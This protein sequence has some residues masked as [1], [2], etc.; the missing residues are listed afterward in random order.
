MHTVERQKALDDVKASL[1]QVREGETL[2]DAAE[3]P[4]DEAIA[5]EEEAAEALETVAEDAE[6]EEDGG[7]TYINEL[8]EQL[9]WEPSELFALKKRID[10]G[11][12]KEPFEVTLGE[13]FDNVDAIAANRAELERERAVLAEQAQALQQQL[14]SVGQANAGMSEEM[15][16]A[17][18]RMKFL[19]DQWPAL[20]EDWKARKADPQEAGK[21]ANERADIIQQYA[22]AKSQFQNAAAQAQQQQAMVVEQFRAHRAQALAGAMPEF[23]DPQKSRELGAEIVQAAA[24]YGVSPEELQL[25]DHRTYLMLLDAAYG[26]KARKGATSAVKGLKK[27]PAVLPKSMKVAKG[28]KA[29]LERAAA[30]ATDRAV[31]TGRQSDKIAAARAVLNASRGAQQSVR[32][33]RHGRR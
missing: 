11:D 28:R 7:I 1:R 19:E 26:L 29:E 15:R 18:A 8:A 16:S 31:E 12:G 5:S 9:G 25:V 10:H 14:A 24:Y 3:Q 2:S 6:A 22:T 23:R 17:E 32:H 20:E 27:A 21:V 33:N 30:E 13:L 4:H